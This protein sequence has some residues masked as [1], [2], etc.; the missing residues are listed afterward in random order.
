MCALGIIV[1]WINNK[2]CLH[3]QLLSFLHLTGS[4]TGSLLAFKV[5]QTLDE[6]DLKK[7][8]FCITGDNTA[9]NM[10]MARHLSNYLAVKDNIV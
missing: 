8:L 4:H 3:Q 10:T 2:F 9:N 7:R 6:Y 1:H 5:Y